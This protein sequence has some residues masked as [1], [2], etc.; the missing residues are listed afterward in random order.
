MWIFTLSKPCCYVSGQTSKR[1]FHHWMREDV[2]LFTTYQIAKSNLWGIIYLQS[3]QMITFS[4][5]AVKAEFFNGVILKLSPSHNG[6]F[7][8]YNTLIFNNFTNGNKF[9]PGYLT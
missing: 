8:D 5:P 9:H 2:I 3:A 1:L 6:M 4:C 7:T